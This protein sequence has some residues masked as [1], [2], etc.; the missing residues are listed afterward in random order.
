[1]P[2]EA[3]SIILQLM[4]KRATNTTLSNASAWV[5]RAVRNETGGFQA[6]PGGGKGKGKGGGKGKG[7]GSYRWV[8]YWAPTSWEGEW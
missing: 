4:N 1:M 8:P 5:W 2:S 6:W 3:R 7:K